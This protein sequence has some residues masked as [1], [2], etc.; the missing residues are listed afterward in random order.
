[1]ESA[2]RPAS[3]EFRSSGRPQPMVHVRQHRAPYPLLLHQIVD[4]YYNSCNITTAMKTNQIKAFRVAAGLTQAQLAKN[5][6]RSQGYV[7]LLE[8][9]LRK[10]GVPLAAQVA[11]AL[12]LPPTAYPLEVDQSD[13]S[14]FDA[15]TVT[16]NLAALGYPGFAYLGRALEPTNPSEV[17]LRT[18]AAEHVDARLL[19]A[20]PW[21]LLHFS[22]FDQRQTVMLAHGS[23]LQNRLGFVVSL[24]RSV[25]ESKHEYAHRLPEL[26]E[27][28]AALEPL[29]LA[30]EDDLGQPFKSERFREWVREHRSEPA[31]HWNL[32]T[33]LGT[34]HLSYAN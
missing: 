6:G 27:L 9:G 13:L 24:A 1:M 12:K 3:C 18:L 7:S 16:R 32:L 31:A 5:L 8:R 28:L 11:R 30:R 19:E 17:L 14:Q 20:M 4:K 10:P 26:D 33:D 21:L 2:I 15:E 29:R 23:S 34:E 25:V 22:D